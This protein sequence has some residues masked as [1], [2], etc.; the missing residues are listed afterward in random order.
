LVKSIAIIYP[1]VVEFNV[2]PFI[3]LLAG[4]K[5]YKLVTILTNDDT[6]T[7]NDFSRALVKLKVI[8][9]LSVTISS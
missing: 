3:T 7:A 5:G 2:A 8:T 9:G 6:L 1:S 4:E